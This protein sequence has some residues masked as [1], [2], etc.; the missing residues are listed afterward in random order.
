MPRTVI[1]Q[2]LIS[3]NDQKFQNSTWIG[4]YM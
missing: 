4:Y 1:L 2:V 3:R